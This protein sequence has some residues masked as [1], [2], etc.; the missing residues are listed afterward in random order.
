L[1]CRPGEEEEDEVL[2]LSLC[3][4]LLLWLWWY[5]DALLDLRVGEEEEERRPNLLK[6]L[7]G[8]WTLAVSKRGDA[9]SWSMSAK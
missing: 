2:I 9:V 6:L 8:E 4:L 1:G 7:M 5:F 3:S